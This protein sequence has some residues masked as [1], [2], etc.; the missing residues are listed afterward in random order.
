MFDIEHQ[1]L[2]WSNFPKE[3]VLF[4]FFRWYEIMDAD[5]YFKYK[6][7]HNIP[8]SLKIFVNK[9]R[10]CQHCQRK[11]QYVVIGSYKGMP[12]EAKNT[13]LL[14][15]KDFLMMT[16]DHIHPK[17]KGGPTK[18]GNLQILCALCNQKKADKVA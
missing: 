11:G 3:S 15:S 8:R 10:E 5:E 12:I 6:N 18:L 13:R 2:F 4:K 9:G 17:S 1:D 14:F 7:I 16:K